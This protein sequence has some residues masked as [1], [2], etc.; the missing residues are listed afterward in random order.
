MPS[1]DEDD[2]DKPNMFTTDIEESG[3]LSCQVK[4]DKILIC[5]KGDKNGQLNNQTEEVIGCKTDIQYKF[6]REKIKKVKAKIMENAT[7]KIRISK[8]SSKD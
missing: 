1:Y 8:T 5:F 4:M 6:S 7:N 2:F 3:E